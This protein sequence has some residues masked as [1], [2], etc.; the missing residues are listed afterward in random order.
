MWNASRRFHRVDTFWTQTCFSIRHGCS[1][2]DHMLTGTLRVVE[3]Q[4]DGGIKGIR[5]VTGTFH[6]NPKSSGALVKNDVI[7][8]ISNLLKINNVAEVEVLT[9]FG[10]RKITQYAL[11]YMTVSE[12][13]PVKDANDKVYN[14]IDG[15]WHNVQV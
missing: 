9:R 13:Y 10:I 3:P 2:V 11:H 6:T 5:V 14:G 15:N 4:T 12:N 8:V 1:S 7:I